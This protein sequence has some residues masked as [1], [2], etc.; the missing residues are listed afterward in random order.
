MPHPFVTLL[1][2]L[3]PR[4]PFIFSGTQDLV[5][6]LILWKRLKGSTSHEAGVFQGSLWYVVS[7]RLTW[8]VYSVSKRQKKSERNKGEKGEE[9][10]KRKQIR[11]YTVFCLSWLTSFTCRKAVLHPLLSPGN[12]SFRVY[13]T[14]CVSVHMPHTAELHQ[15]FC[16]E[17]LCIHL[18]FEDTA[19]IWPMYSPRSRKPF[20]HLN[21]W[22]NTSKYEQRLIKTSACTSLL[23]GGA[24]GHLFMRSFV[25]WRDFI[26]QYLEKSS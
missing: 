23:N 2:Y 21:F 18:F 19:L 7:L 22:G 10:N 9:E 8:L 20:K 3:S 6:V 26:N 4:K 12:S 14:F 16:F 13:I 1:S 5:V 11:K 15:F 25:I 17:L 24:T